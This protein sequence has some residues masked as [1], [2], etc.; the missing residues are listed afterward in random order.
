[1]APSPA[2][3]AVHCPETL[4]R[5]F[6]LLGKRWT[7]QIIAVL[8]ERPARFAELARAV[9]GISE[10]MLSARL[11]ELKEAGL[12]EREVK[13]GPPISSI[14]R[15]TKSGEALRSGLLALGQWAEVYLLDRSKAKAA[16]RR[17]SRRPA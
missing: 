15:L 13:D 14:Y 5:V 6:S 17:A 3:R 9:P 7:G 11:R 12:V 8:L 16:T 1:M 4:T 2:E 10:G